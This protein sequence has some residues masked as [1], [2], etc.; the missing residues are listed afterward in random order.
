MINFRF[1][2]VSIV[3]V[4]L[5]LALGI[6]IGSTVVDR[7]IVASLRSQIERV[8]AN[9][10]AQ[11]A[12]NAALSEELG[13]K[14]EYVNATASFAVSGRLPAVALALIAESNV[15]EDNLVSFI[16]LSRNAGSRVGGFL[17]LTEKWSDDSQVS[18]LRSAAGVEE[19]GAKLVR[20]AAWSAV[21]QRLAA[22]VG[23]S[24]QE[25]VLVRLDA[26]GFIEFKSIGDGGAGAPAF[27]A[28]WPGIEARALYI[29]APTSGDIS[30]Q[31]QRISE[32][33]SA[34][35]RQGM[36]TV[37]SENH[38][39]GDGVPARGLLLS[40]VLDDA[41]LRIRISS[42]D[43]FELIEGRV[44]AVLAAADLA[45]GVNGRYGYGDGAVAVS[46]EWWAL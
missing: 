9:A 5:S 28:E 45:R 36:L 44:S 23:T 12:E 25:D 21:A 46:P 41:G 33:V 7:A 20:A 17:L 1:H 13:L 11:R 42:V 32:R 6:M 27:P 35:A 10:D 4:F 38:V 29:S 34:L 8:E 18:Q 19:R 30:P 37:A 16:E 3:A 31:S 22:G 39:D 40:N 15:S 2:V 14:G 43:N 26:A 24:T